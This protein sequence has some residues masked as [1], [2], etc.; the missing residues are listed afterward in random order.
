MDQITSFETT[1]KLLEA[2]FPKSENW[3]HCY[4]VVNGQPVLGNPDSKTIRAFT[5]LDILE[6]LG[7]GFSLTFNQ[8][9]Q[10]WVCVRMLETKSTG[11]KNSAEAVAEMY[12]LQKQTK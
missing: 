3:G 2:G 11:N 12:F 1:K 7:L 9:L 8:N 10:S 6:H 5:A 4:Y